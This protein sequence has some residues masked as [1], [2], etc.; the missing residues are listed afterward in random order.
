[1]AVDAWRARTFDSFYPALAKLS[2][3]DIYMYV[4]DQSHTGRSFVKTY[5][6]RVLNRTKK[7]GLLRIRFN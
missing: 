2:V 4:P 6:A 3:Y 5:Q 7:I 1:M